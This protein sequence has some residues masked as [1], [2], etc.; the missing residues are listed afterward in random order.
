[1]QLY[2][3]KH[4][5]WIDHRKTREYQVRKQTLRDAWIYGLLFS[6]LLPPGIQIA[7]VI[8]GVCLSFCYLDETPYKAP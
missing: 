7:A 4:N 2:D 6:L 1:M 8:F 5:R 3:K